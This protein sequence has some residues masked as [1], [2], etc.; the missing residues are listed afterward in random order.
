MARITDG[1]W[2]TPSPSSLSTSTPVDRA[3]VAQHLQRDVVAPDVE[4]GRGTVQRA[5]DLGAGGVAAGVDDPTP[6]WPPSRV[7]DHRPG[8]DSSK[9]APRSTNRRPPR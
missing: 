3:V 2:T 1:A 4:G 7:S 9:R 5:L 8:A 6:E